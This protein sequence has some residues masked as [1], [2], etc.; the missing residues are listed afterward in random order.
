TPAAC[1]RVEGQTLGYDTDLDFM[2][3]R[4]LAVFRTGGD[5]AYHHGGIS[6]QEMV[7]PVLSLRIPSAK[8]AAEAG[9]PVTLE[10]YPA[11]VT[12]RT[13]GLR[14]TVHKRDLFTEEP[15]PVRLVLVAGGQEVGRAGMAVDTRHACPP[16]GERLDR[17][18]G[19]VMASFAEE[20][21]VAMILTSDRLPNGDE[22]TKVRIVAQDP[23]TDAILG[24]SEELPVKLGI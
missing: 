22:V 13:F 17:A 19:T 1:L 9:A 20:I 21:N 7:V 3:P 23:A 6:L 18:T 2:F 4:G 8:I 10:G 12:N 16:S 5:L 15:V 14:L 11:V 24:Q